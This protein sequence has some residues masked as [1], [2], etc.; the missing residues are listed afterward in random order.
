MII[1]K[2]STFEITTTNSHESM[3][4]SHLPIIGHKLNG[5]NFLQWSQSV[6]IF[7]CG[8]GKDDYLTGSASSP[9]KQDAKFKVW[10]AKNNMVMSCLINSMNNDRIEFSS[11]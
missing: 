7:I 4:K 6:M 5:Q 11:L 10:N 2:F 3:D 1:E 9:N 8:K